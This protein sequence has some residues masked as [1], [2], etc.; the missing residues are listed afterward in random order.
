MLIRGPHHKDKADAENF[1]CN[2]DA[3]VVGNDLLRPCRAKA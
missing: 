1:D 2:F 3:G